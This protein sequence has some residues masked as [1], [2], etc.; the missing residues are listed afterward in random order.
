VT[1]SPDGQVVASGSLDGPVKLWDVRT[2]Q[3]LRFR[4][5]AML[6]D[7]AEH[8]H[9]ALQADQEKQPFAAACRLG[10]AIAARLRLQVSPWDPT[11]SVHVVANAGGPAFSANA[12]TVVAGWHGLDAGRQAQTAFVDGATFAGILFKD[13]GRSA[14]GLV[15]RAQWAVDQWPAG[16]QNHE[17]LGGALYR[18]GDFQG[19][20]RE[21]MES[22]KLR[23]Q[24]ANVGQDSAPV[25][26]TGQERSPV[27]RPSIWS[28]HFLA[29]AHH[30]LGNHDDARAW[31][32]KAVLPKDAPWEDAMLD[33]TLRREVG[34]ELKKQ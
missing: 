20:V 28:C 17:V 6:P 3:E 15:V 29:L 7:P 33:R 30:K 22:Q 18:A 10:H 32:N 24:A 26:K 14:K 9:H 31:F 16:W 1:F 11:G 4:L 8:R 5:T 23:S 34:T 27:L 12:A 19:A 21:L 2:R 25:R 13:S